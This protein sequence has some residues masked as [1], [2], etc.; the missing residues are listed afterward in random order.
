MGKLG[1]GVGG[2][3]G[4]VTGYPWM[5]MC[6]W[7]QLDATVPPLPLLL[8]LFPGAVQNSGSGRKESRPLGLL[9]SCF[10]LS[11]ADAYISW[12]V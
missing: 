1:G 8:L 11:P 5:S 7:M 10:P 9:A 12:V 4:D 2:C 3:G 6:Q